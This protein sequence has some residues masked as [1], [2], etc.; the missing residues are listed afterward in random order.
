MTTTSTDVPLH[1]I[2]ADAIV[3]AIG[4]SELYGPAKELNEH[5]DGALQRMIDNDEVSL[6]TGVTTAWLTPPGLHTALVMLVGTGKTD[7]PTES[8]YFKAAGAASLTLA[9]KKRNQ[10]AFYFPDLPSNQLEAAITGSLIGCHGQDLCRDKR[11][12]HPPENILWSTSEDTTLQSA[13]RIASG[14]NLTRD[15]VNGPPNMIYPE[16]FAEQIAQLHGESGLQVEIWDGAKLAQENCG[17]LLAVAQGS[18][19]EARLAIIRYHGSECD[20]PQLALVGKGVTYDSGGL[21]LKPSEGQKTMK[22]DMAGAATVVGTMKAIAQLELPCHVIGIVGLVEN[23]VSANA[24]RLGDVIT[25]RNGKTIEVLNTDAEGRLVLADALDIA[26]EN[27]PSHI[28]DLATLTG[29]CCVALGLDVAGLMTNDQAWC[30]RLKTAAEQ[31]GEYVWQLPMFEEFGKELQSKVADL[32]NI[33]AGRWGGAIT[34]GKF[35]EEFVDDVSWTHI[36]IAG[37]AFADSPKKW[38]DA[39]ASGVMVRTLVETIRKLEPHS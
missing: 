23:M 21:S 10:V 17:S 22:C 7:S 26:V 11:N 15:L 33:G 2:E 1:E 5:T 39:G 30:D 28:V 3:V 6:K 36:D 12:L 32:R 20:N 24:Y 9:S 34:A 25:A 31:T 8:D 16:S 18:A 37:P 14:I 4:G 19:R 38:I 29:A 35:L 13:C 27:K